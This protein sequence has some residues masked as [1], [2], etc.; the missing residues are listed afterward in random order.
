MKVGNEALACDRRAI[1]E[2]L[3]RIFCYEFH[4]YVGVDVPQIWSQIT[5]F[6]VCIEHK[7]NAT[8][9]FK[10]MAHVIIRFEAV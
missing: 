5:S 3:Q 6:P 4:E 10:M 1:V 2:F 8:C 9:G 7:F